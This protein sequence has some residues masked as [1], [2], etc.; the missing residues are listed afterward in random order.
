[1]A[2]TYMGKPYYPAW[3]DNL[4]DDVTGEGPAWDGVIQG[5][6]AVHEVWS[7]QKN[8]TSF[9]SSTMRAPAGKTVFSRTT[10]HR[11]A[12]CLSLSSFWLS[13]TPPGRLSALW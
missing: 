3:L 11:S 10:L 5:A 12:V 7:P 8:Y 6:A 1:M 9:R 4:A 2:S 13:S